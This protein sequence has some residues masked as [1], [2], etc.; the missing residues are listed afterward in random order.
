MNR[1]NGLLRL[2]F[3]PGVGLYAIEENAAITNC[4][5]HGLFIGL[6]G[7]LW[8]RLGFEV[9]RATA[10]PCCYPTRSLPMAQ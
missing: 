5:K 3:R 7:V 2:L 1:Y 10:G 6:E 4:R 9:G 8:V